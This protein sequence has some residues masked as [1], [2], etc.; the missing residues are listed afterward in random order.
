MVVQK[1]GAQPNVPSRTV[2]SLERNIVVQMYVMVTQLACAIE[3]VAA[4]VVVVTA[5]LW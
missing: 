1:I 2:F 5:V 4:V 3:I